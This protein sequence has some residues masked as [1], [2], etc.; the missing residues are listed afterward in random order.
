MLTD[1]PQSVLITLQAGQGPLKTSRPG[2][3]SILTAIPLNYTVIVVF[4]MSLS[5]DV[6]AMS[7]FPVQVVLGVE[8]RGV[9]R[10]GRNRELP[11]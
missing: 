8:E 3:F 9:C 2:Q 7:R 11:T 6:I 10:E 4:A 1:R 5:N